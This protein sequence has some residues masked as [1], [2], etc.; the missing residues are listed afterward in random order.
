[1]GGLAREPQNIS[2]D[3]ESGI[4]S[5]RTGLLVGTQPVDFFLF[6]LNETNLYAAQYL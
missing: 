6:F 4:S 2:F 3:G 1:M 5:E